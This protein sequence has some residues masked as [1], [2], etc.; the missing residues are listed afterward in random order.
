VSIERGQVV[1]SLAGRD[2]GE[3]AVVIDSTESTVTVAN[4]KSRPIARPK[5]KNLKHVQITAYRLNISEM[6]SDR[7]LRR[8][9]NRLQPNHQ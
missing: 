8:Q 1:L 9:L 3:Y 4:G 7:W 2:A 5:T 6:A